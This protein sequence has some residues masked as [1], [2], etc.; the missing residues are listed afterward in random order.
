MLAAKLKNMAI[1]F[2]GFSRDDMQSIRAHVLVAVGDRDV[3]RLEHAIDMFRII[4]H[5][6]LAVFPDT[7]HSI[8]ERSLSTIAAF[9]ND[10]A[11]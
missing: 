4:K 7:D 11:P 2:K 10:L 1:E 9:L 8:T 5:A 6:Q 3:I